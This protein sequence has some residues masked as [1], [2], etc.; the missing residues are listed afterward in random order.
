MG[1]MKAAMGQ[2]RNAVQ[3]NRLA[4]L[5]VCLHCLLPQGWVPPLAT[6]SLNPALPDDAGRSF[7][8]QRRN[9]GWSMSMASA[10]VGCCSQER[11]A[12]SFY[13]V[14]LSLCLNL[15]DQP[16]IDRLIK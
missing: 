12:Y 1:T 13:G 2:S 15:I 7:L 16:L 8:N 14:V 10:F 9:G 5:A 3:I 6:P 4:G 11:R